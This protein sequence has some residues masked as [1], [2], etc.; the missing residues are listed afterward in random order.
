MAKFLG[1]RL[2]GG[3]NFA[4]VSA[5]VRSKK[6]KLI[7]PD[8]WPKL[9]LRDTSDIARF[10][11]EGTYK[12]EVD[13][14]AGRYRGAELVERATRLQVG[15]V[16]SEIL[17]YASGELSLVIGQYLAR[18]D[19]Y[20][21][22]TLLRGRFSNASP[23][24]TLSETIPTGMLA[25]RLAELSRAESLEDLADAL[26]STPYGKLLAQHLE[27]R[28]PQNLMALE[29]D[30]DRFYYENLLASVS[31][32]GAANRAFHSW[33]RNEIDVVNLK[34][35]FRLR[36][37]RVTDWEPYF[38]DGGAQ[39]GRESAQRIV[40]G[41]DDEA[42]SELAGMSLGAD[43]P[44]AARR[45]IASG[46]VSAVAGALDKEIIRDASDFSH[47]MP[48]SVLPVVDFILR[49]KVEADN[50][51][52]IAYGK[53]TALPNETIQELLL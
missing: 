29:N 28:A 3:G 16:Y 26:K 32:R 52:A 13:E 7:S 24:Q 36:F 33:V 23:E 43:V 21:V 46:T 42:I 44:E 39:V 4:Y 49:K 35:L 22:K 17:G 12:D 20:N 8:E 10:L 51:R 19:V 18:Y 50:L 38:L 25:G 14:L 5:R 2:G 31:T 45:S 37:A 40:R 6:A 15:R 11:Q 48:L 47:R 30:L 53:Q 41:S 34:T 27:G 1:L 9:L